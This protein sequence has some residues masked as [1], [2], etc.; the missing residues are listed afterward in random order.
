M[1]QTKDT[2]CEEKQKC[3]KTL[4]AHLTGE[5]A[6]LLRQLR[7]IA[8]TTLTTLPVRATWTVRDILVHLGSW[9]AFHTE[10]MSMVLNGRINAIRE[11]GAED[12]I[13]ARN[14][15]ILTFSQNLSLEQALAICLQER[16]SF[17]AALQ[18]IPDDL[19]CETVVMPWG[20]QTSIQQWTEWRYQH[21]AQ[22]A[23]E[24]KTWRE[25]LAQSDRRQIGPIFLLRAILKATRKEFLSL[26]DLVPAADRT[27][28]PVCGVWTLKDL[29]GHLTDWEKV[30][31]DGLRQL[32]AG[33][34]PEFD[35][36]IT[37]FDT[38]NNAH[39]AARHDQP[40][41]EV[42]AEFE[43]TR[44]ELVSL[45]DQMG[46]GDWARPFTAPWDSQINGYFWVNVWSGHDHEHAHDVRNAIGLA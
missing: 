27:T 8:A 3:R 20:W 15:D 40:W 35:E 44:Q 1:M 43:Q 34:T 22:H 16:S 38:W 39:A 23:A 33:Q 2:R 6:N 28:F 37:D 11:L 42:W 21:D 5:R 17:L 13:D 30:G 12:A 9:D 46:E 4:L 26:A 32:A 41:N 7:G 14:A 31:V 18:R 36:L 19:L 10:R 25:Q 29:I 24:L 45:V